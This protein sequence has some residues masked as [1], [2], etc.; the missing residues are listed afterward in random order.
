[1]IND[2]IARRERAGHP[3][4]R[5][6]DQRPR[7]WIEP[8]NGVVLVVDNVPMLQKDAEALLRRSR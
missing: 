5:D 8:G 1:M 2:L 4:G 6:S 3:V 7:V